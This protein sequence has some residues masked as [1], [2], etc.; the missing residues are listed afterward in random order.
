MTLP[1]L[2]KDVAIKLGIES[3]IHVEA[4]PYKL[5]LYEEGGHFQ[6]H[7]DSE[8]ESGMF[9]TLL[10]QLPAAYEGGELLI[11]LGKN[12]RLLSLS[13]DSADKSFYTGI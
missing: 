3:H 8:K 5:L 1:S 12:S 11:E 6:K 4:H 2:V 13:E 7:K 10:I 9:G